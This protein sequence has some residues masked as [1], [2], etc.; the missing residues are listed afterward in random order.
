MVIYKSSERYKFLNTAKIQKKNNISCNKMKF[1]GSSQKPEHVSIA[2]SVE[3][4]PF[5]Q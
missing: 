3:Q 2:Q 1:S 5:K 4:L